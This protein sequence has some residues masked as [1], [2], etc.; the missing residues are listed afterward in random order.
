MST[1]ST[2]G[3][4]WSPLPVATARPLT[5]VCTHPR[6]APAPRSP[7]CPTRRSW[8]IRALR[9]APGAGPRTGGRPWRA[10]VAEEGRPVVVTGAPAE[11]DACRTVAGAHPEV[12]DLCGDSTCTTS[13]RSSVP[14]G[15]FCP[16]TPGSLT[17][18]RPT[19][20]RP[21]CSS[22]RPLRASGV[23]A[24]TRTC[25]ECS[26]GPR[27]T[28]LPATRTATHGRPARADRGRGRARRSAQPVSRRGSPG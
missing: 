17:W 16:A 12:T 15:S 14:P 3:A 25:T 27:R 26:G 24:S 7:A 18:R 19:A 8:S 5:S 4:D 9:P 28:T 2:D 23:R 10:G 6:P 21:S 22:A 1:R 11:R 13:P 20:R